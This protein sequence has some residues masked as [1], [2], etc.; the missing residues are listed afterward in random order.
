MKKVFFTIGA[1]LLCLVLA[2]LQLFAGGE[3]EKKGPVTVTYWTAYPQLQ[4]TVE[5]AGKLYTKDHPNVKVESVLFP[6]R[7]MNEKVAVALPAGEGAD[8]IDFACFEIFPYYVNGYISNPPTDV[9]DYL[10]EQF[11]SF[12]LTSAT[13]PDDG[14]PFTVPYYVS[15]KEMFYNKDYFA[16]AGLA[17]KA[18]KTLDEQIEFAK[19]LT[20]K[21]AAGNITRVGLDLRLAGGGFGTA[22]KYW[23]QVMVAYGAKPIV[24]VGD[25]WKA[26]YAN[27]AGYD[28]LQYYLDAIYKHKVES[29]EAKSDAEG[30]GLGVS[31]MFQRESWVVN[32]LKDNAPNI[33]YGVFFMPEGPAGGGTVGNTQSL[34]VPTS[35]K[36]KRQ[37][38]DFAKF[39]MSPEIQVMIY[40]DSG[41]QS[42]N[43]KA[44][45]SV[46]YKDS[47]ALESFMKALNTKGHPIYDYENIPPIM[48]VHARMADRLM[49]AFKQENLATNRGELKKVVDKIAE[50][51]NQ[52]LA[53]FDLLAK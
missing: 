51:T 32:H 34:S 27:E 17:G 20:K 24:K 43:I 29:H 5:A 11:P 3:A 45:Y 7:A 46:L 2:N 41:W 12:T 33:N 39:L 4:S 6:Q 53:D 36:V 30:F 47:P 23:A 21:D 8:L 31:A 48:E 42:L 16:E 38:W 26:G 37:A 13:S 40:K 22:Q 9:I 1:I 25:K 10:K 49:V 28:C 14:K 50:E 35:S 19:K 44:N 52:I 15:L 18:P